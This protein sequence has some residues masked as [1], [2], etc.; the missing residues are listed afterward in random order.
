MIQ[1]FFSPEMIYALGWTLI[2]T[3]WQG[4]LFACL[5]A[6]T[7]IADGGI[8]CPMWEFEAIAVTSSPSVILSSLVAI[9][10]IRIG[11]L[12]ENSIFFTKTGFCSGVMFPNANKSCVPLSSFVLKGKII[13]KILYHNFISQESQLKSPASAQL[14]YLNNLLY[15]RFE[16]VLG[17]LKLP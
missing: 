6:I 12:E 9:S 3:L 4:A 1:H 13:I 16:I 5:L 8:G 2:H 11:E 15:I 10:F 14:Q 17:M 7:F